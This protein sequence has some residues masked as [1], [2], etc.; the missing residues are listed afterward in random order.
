MIIGGHIIERWELISE[1]CPL[2]STRALQHLCAYTH[3]HT[4]TH[5]FSSL[6]TW[7]MYQ[8]CWSSVRMFIV[9][10]AVPI[11]K[12]YFTAKHWVLEQ[13]LTWLFLRD[14][15]AGNCRKTRLYKLFLLWKNIDCSNIAFLSHGIL[16]SYWVFFPWLFNK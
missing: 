7:K 10:I 2:T 9:Q 8:N 15:E 13:C 4:H 1:S 6:L 14:L 12:A 5:H 3:T 16:V 11:Y